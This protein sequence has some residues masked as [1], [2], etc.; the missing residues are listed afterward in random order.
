L[1]A[2]DNLLYEIT[3][4]DSASPT[5]NAW[6]FHMKVTVDLSAVSGTMNVERM[7]P[8]EGNVTRGEPIAGGGQ[9][10]LKAPFAGDSVLYL[11][12]N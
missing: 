7:D 12:R 11:W 5:N 8:T 10:T 6:Q 2:R 1:K 3:N 4:E 9:R